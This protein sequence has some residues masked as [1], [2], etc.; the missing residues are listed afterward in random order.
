LK[1]VSFN[2][3][4]A[5]LVNTGYKVAPIHSKSGI[6]ANVSFGIYFFQIYKKNFTNK[7]ASYYPAVQQSFNSFHFS[8]GFCIE[9]FSRNYSFYLFENDLDTDNFR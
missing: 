9:I 4:I 5:L 1:I 7:K 8:Q 3:V 2:L 6:L